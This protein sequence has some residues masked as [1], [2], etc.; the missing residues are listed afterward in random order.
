MSG[1]STNS[2]KRNPLAS[3]ETYLNYVQ[4]PC[5]PKMNDWNIEIAF[6]RTHTA[7][8]AD[9]H[10][11]ESEGSCVTKTFEG[12]ANASKVRAFKYDYAPMDD[13]PES[14][15]ISDFISSSVETKRETIV[16]SCL[17]DGD[18]VK[19]IRMNHM[20][21]SEE[22]NSE[23]HE[24]S[25]AA[26]EHKRLDSTVAELS[27]QG[28]RGCCLHTANEL[29]FIRKKL[30]EIESKQSSLLDLVQV[31]YSGSLETCVTILFI[32]ENIN[33]GHGFH[34]KSPRIG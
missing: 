1:M 18:S 24:C 17:G 2:T 26:P 20:S 10:N 19:T 31:F 25:L 11:E 9:T 13:K 29:A 3:R 8:L 22:T 6:P 4:S 27:S 34:L 21:P 14:Y 30:L 28:L 12:N 16:N 7:S 33:L 32:V 23:L 5:Q 15:S